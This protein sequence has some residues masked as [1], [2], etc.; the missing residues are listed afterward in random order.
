M[1]KVTAVSM[2]LVL[3][4]GT[5]AFATLTDTIQSQLTQ[6]QLGNDVSLLHGSQ[7]AG[8]LQNLVVNNNQCTSGICNAVTNEGL[9]A[10]IGQSANTIG[11]CALVGVS[12][13]LEVAGQQQQEVAEGVGAKAQIQG[14]GMAATQSLGKSD[15]QGSADALHTM[16]LQATQTGSNSAGSLTESSTVMGMQTSTLNG[17][18]GATGLVDASM[19]VTT[20]QTQGAL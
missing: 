3:A 19:A 12:Q 16:V 9:F 1:L 14:L 15:G 17:C 18:A 20:T 5:G 7:T 13:G 11:N 4:I 2:V 8:S 10:S 6:I